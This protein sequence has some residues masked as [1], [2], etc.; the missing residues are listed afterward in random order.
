MRRNLVLPR[1]FAL[2]CAA[3]FAAVSFSRA[4]IVPVNLGDFT[5]QA[6]VITFSEAGHPVGQTNPVYN[7]ATASLGNVTVS[8]GQSFVGQT[9]AGSDVR[10]ITGTPT[11]PLTLNAVGTE[12]VTDG[13][14][15]TS[16]VLSGSPI[17][18]GPISM[19]FSTGVAFVGL[20]GGYFDAIGGTSIQAFDA[21]GVSLGSVTNSKLGIEFLGLSMVSG[22]NVIRGLSFYITGSEPD[23]F[24]ID[25][26]TFGSARELVRPPT[27]VPEPST[28]GLIGAAVLVG[29]TLYRRRLQAKRAA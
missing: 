19:L 1:R 29:A 27:P 24:A 8:F 25:N 13:A 4:Q 15:P 22:A 17:F 21:N 20:N 23:G 16:P 7:L 11:G 3:F 5:P 2:S 14:N 6:S 26:V 18:N 9:V 10:T 28:Y 12:I